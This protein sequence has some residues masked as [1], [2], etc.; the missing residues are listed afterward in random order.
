M[1]GDEPSGFGDGGPVSKVGEA[2]D[3]VAHGIVPGSGSPSGATERMTR[4]RINGASAE[5]AGGRTVEH[6]GPDAHP[7]RQHVVTGLEAGAVGGVHG[8]QPGMVVSRVAKLAE[9][10]R[11]TGVPAGF[12]AVNNVSGVPAVGDLARAAL[13]GKVAAGLGFVVLVAGGGDESVRFTDG[14]GSP[15][16]ALGSLPDIGDDAPGLSSVI[17]VELVSPVTRA[18]V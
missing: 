14:G 1:S 2:E 11:S 6:G 17:R 7:R 8:P 12:K 13:D 16:V 4:E 10:P 15:R 3:L 9:Q 18:G 5:G